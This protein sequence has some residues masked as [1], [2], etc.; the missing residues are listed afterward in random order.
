MCNVISLCT[1]ISFVIEMSCNETTYIA[2]T[3]NFYAL[4]FCAMLDIV[5]TCNYFYL[6]LTSTVE[7]R[8]ILIANKTGCNFRH[9]TK[10]E[11]HH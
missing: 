1:S 6:I 5:K 2:L 11:V 4:H 7:L 9:D 8:N 10:L 3:I